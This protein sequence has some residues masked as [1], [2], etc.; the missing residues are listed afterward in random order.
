[1]SP[2]SIF[3]SPDGIHQLQ[4]LIASSFPELNNLSSRHPEPHDLIM[5]IRLHFPIDFQAK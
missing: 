1:M 2:D 5:I 3:M 4:N